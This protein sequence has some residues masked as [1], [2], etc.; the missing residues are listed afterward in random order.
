M[1]LIDADALAADMYQRAFET[2]TPLQRWDGGCWIRY[3][4][5]EIAIK[6]APTIERKI[7]TC[8]DCDWW[9]KQEDS[10][11][12]R[13]ARFGIYPTGSWYCAGAEERKKDE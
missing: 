10:L 13:C 1:R 11:E 8:N 7:I 6:E 9:T 2:D 5:F 3:K 12:G 4:M